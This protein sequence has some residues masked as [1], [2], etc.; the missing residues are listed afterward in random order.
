MIRV[1]TTFHDME[2]AKE[3]SYDLVD[4]GLVS[5]ANVSEVQSVY[6]WNDDIVESSEIAVDYKTAR[7]FEEVNDRLKEL[8]PYDTPLILEKK[9]P[10]VNH[11]G[12]EWLEE[13]SGVGAT[14]V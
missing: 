3:V 5:C 4:E 9:I 11:K 8:H 1:Y 2:T 12:E 7:S 6:E 13:T 10:H 14:E